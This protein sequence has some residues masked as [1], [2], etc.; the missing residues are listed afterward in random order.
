MAALSYIATL[1]GSAVVN[2]WRHRTMTVI[3]VLIV[4]LM[5]TTLGMFLLVENALS[6]MIDSL[7]EQVNLIVYLHDDAPPADVLALQ[8]RLQ[9]DPLMISVEYVTKEKALERLRASFPDQPDFLQALPG[10]PLPASLDVRSDDPDH[11]REQAS[12]LTAE[13]IVEDVVLPQDVV[14]LLIRISQA[15]RI[16]GYTLGAGLAL[17]ALFVIGSTIRLT[18]YARRGEIEVL[19]LMGAS[20]H[21]IRWPFLLEGI[22]FGLLGALFASLIVGAAYVSIHEVLQ[23]L[24]SF[25][26]VSLDTAYLF[27]LILMMTLFGIVVGALGSYLSVRRFLTV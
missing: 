19:R 26:P 22:F 9:D 18:V 1:S 10:N 7:E 15:V 20:D 25:L 17:V 27:R 13:P 12:V 3:T 23:Q 2:A 6:V 14:E 21:F 5:M 24:I 8:R 4:S 16:L 11:L